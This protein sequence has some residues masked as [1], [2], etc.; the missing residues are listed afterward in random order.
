MSDSR[1][2]IKTLP[3]RPDEVEVTI[4]VSVGNR[5]LSQR[6]TGYLSM[7][8]ALRDAERVAR[9]W[10]DRTANHLLDGLTAAVLAEQKPPDD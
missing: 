5:I 3:E 6:T 4:N 7:G 10:A 1:I 8:E 9:E 2:D